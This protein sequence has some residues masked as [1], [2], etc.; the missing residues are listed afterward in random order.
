MA[1]RRRSRSYK[2]VNAFTKDMGSA[3]S[4]V[5]LGRIDK[6]QAQGITGWFNNVIVSYLASDTST[7]DLNEENV[8]CMLYLTS[9]G[10]WDDDLVITA[11]AGGGNGTTVNLVAK[12]AIHSND[13]SSGHEDGN[14]GPV[15]LWGELT[16]ATGT[17]NIDARIV[18]ECWGRYIEFTEL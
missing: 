18:T 17:A 11:R 13:V 8:G 16:D 7:G 2:L 9:D 10:V 6:V 4:Q 12:R 3:G 14:I 1:R 15:Y 5:L